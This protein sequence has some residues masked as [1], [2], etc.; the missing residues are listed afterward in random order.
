MNDN[1]MLMDI[2]GSRLET[3][4][5]VTI[6][7]NGMEAF[8]IV[9]SKARHHFDIILMDI[10]MPIMDGFQAIE[11]IQEHMQQNKL[12]KILSIMD[13]MDCPNSPRLDN[14][15]DGID[16]LANPI[17]AQNDALPS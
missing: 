13:C 5:S 15:S 4:F 10:N 9:K 17:E 11:K 1:A 12:S 6:A 16:E 14:P 2:F 3:T 7:F 8:D